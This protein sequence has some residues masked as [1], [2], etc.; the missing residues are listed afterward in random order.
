MTPIPMRRTPLLRSCML[1]IIGVGFV[2]A[3]AQAQQIPETKRHF[4]AGENLSPLKL[5]PLPAKKIPSKKFGDW[6]Q[7]C[8]TRPGVSGRKCFLTQTVIQTKDKNRQ[9]LLAITIGLIGPDQKPSM[10]LRVPLELG[11]LLPPGF[12]FNVPGIEPTQIVVQSCLP[13]GCIA[14]MSL[15]PDIVAAMEKSE[16]GSLEVHTIRKKVIRIP[17]SF[18]GFTAALASLVNGSDPS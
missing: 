17:V 2:V 8:K 18:K 11:V 3:T 13:I 12:K 1:V 6:T 10:A 16:A 4:T 9:G 15:M 7:L 14:K 5:P